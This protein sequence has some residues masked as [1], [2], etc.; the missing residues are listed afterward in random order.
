MKRTQCSEV[1][2]DSSGRHRCGNMAAFTLATGEAVCR[3]H[4][5]SKK[6]RGVKAEKIPRV[7][8]TAETGWIW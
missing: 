3:A 5:R 1:V 8:D 2:V 6:N 7:Y 4:R